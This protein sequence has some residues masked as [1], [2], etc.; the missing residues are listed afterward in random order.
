MASVNGPRAAPASIPGKPFK[1]ARKNPLELGLEVKVF[2]KRVNQVYGECPLDLGLV[3]DLAAQIDPFVGVEC[4]HLHPR[5]ECRDNGK[6]GR[7]DNQDRRK[8]RPAATRS[9]RFCHRLRFV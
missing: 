9:G 6:Q 8:F 2:V 7:D 4:L 1:V 5:R 3:E